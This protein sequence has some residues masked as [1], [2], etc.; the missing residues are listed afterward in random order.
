VVG[1][2]ASL[3][4]VEVDIANGLYSFTIIGLGDKAVDESRERV[5]A[6]L[7]HAGVQPPKQKNERVTVSLAPAHTRKH[8]PLFDLA[9]AVGYLLA[10]E[11]VQI[12]YPRSLFVGELSLNGMVRGVR[13]TLPIAQRAK[14]SG[15]THLY[16]PLENAQEAAV[17]DGV[18]VYGVPTLSALI[19]HL[20]GCKPLA[21]ESSDK[22]VVQFKKTMLASLPSSDRELSAIRGQHA[23]KRAAMI[24]AAG[25]H[26]IALCGPP[27]TGKT[28]LARAIRE[29]LPPLTEAEA[30]VVHTIHSAAGILQGEPTTQRPFRAPHHSSSAAAI[31]GGGAWLRPG[32]LTL[33]HHGVLLLDEFP[34]FDR[35]TIEALRQPLEDGCITL[36]RANGSVTYPASS[37]L[38][39]T[40]NPCPCGY[41]GHPQKPCT[42]TAAHILRYKTKLSGPIIDRIDVWVSMEDVPHQTLLEPAT[43]ERQIET[44]GAHEIIAA[45]RQHALQRQG[46]PNARLH[47]KA[48]STHTTLE[49]EIHTMFIQA[50]QRLNVSARSTHKI[51]RI[52]RTIADLEHR[53]AITLPDILEALQYRKSV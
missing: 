45:A 51:L 20:K 48:L 25:E 11:T 37:M 43:H 28:L 33:A 35:E 8:G 41:L 1:I 14:E 29:L 16:V 23:A 52:A 53:S 47:G 15:I 10:S 26:N 40:L 36:A 2:Q 13:G 44:G 34:E 21:E 42:C 7:K 3:V 18:I 27:G 12:Q 32:E 30:F 4:D 38:I 39:A 49:P 19:R 24:A 46:V 22:Q 17:V 6:A 50:L 5:S 31:I 9:I